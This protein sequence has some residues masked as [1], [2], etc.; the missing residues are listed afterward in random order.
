MRTQ[1]LKRVDLSKVKIGDEI[2]IIHC[3][4][5]DQPIIITGSID[6]NSEYLSDGSKIIIVKVQKIGTVIVQ[7]TLR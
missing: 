3:N 6:V 1:P 4:E 2:K 5:R 7:K